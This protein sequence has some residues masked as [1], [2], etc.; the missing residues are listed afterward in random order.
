MRA[1]LFFRRAFLSL[2][3]VLAI[4]GCGAHKSALPPAE[5]APP[6]VE[7]EAGV[8]EAK[9]NISYSHPGDYL[10]SM[11]VTKYSGAHVLQTTE[12]QQGAASIVRF[13]GDV[14][15]WQFNLQQSLIGGLPLVGRTAPNH[16]AP[17]EVTYGTLPTGFI[18]TIPDM[19]P[20]EPLEPNEYYIFAVTRGSGSVS[21]EAVKVN[22]DGSLEAYEGDPRA[23][24]SYLLCCNL[25]PDFT[26][27]PPPP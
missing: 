4:V 15:V 18:Q 19:G 17:K 9:I 25:A 8:P 22:G 6:P 26:L 20:P 24:T 5:Q 10:S 1:S 23:G 11:T 27:T 16:P 3:L 14:V 21:Y 2:P 7:G 13:D 12:T